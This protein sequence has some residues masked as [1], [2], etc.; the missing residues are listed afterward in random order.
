[1]RFLPQRAGEDDILLS[2]ASDK[3]VRAWRRTG[4]TFTLAATVSGVHQGSVNVLATCREH[5]GVF[6]SGAA[7]GSVAIFKIEVGE[8]VEMK[9]L[10]TITTT[11]KFYALS[12][13][14]S[15]LPTSP[16]ALILAMGGSMNNISIYAAP[17][18]T[19]PFVHCAIL[20]GH[21]NWIRSLSFTIE[22]QTSA[23]PSLLLA[24]AS[25]DR[26]IRLWRIH[27][28]T[29]LPAAAAP[30]P[31]AALN[32][33]LSNKAHML[34]LPDRAGSTQTWSVTFEALLMGHEDWI[35]TCHWSPT[36]QLLSCSADNAITIW[37]RE[38]DSGTWNPVSRFGEL[39]S[40]KGSSTATGSA[41]G[42][43]NALWSPQADAVAALTKTGSWR[44]YR[45]DSTTD[46]WNPSIGITGHT[47]SVT[48]ISWSSDGGYLLSTSLDQTTRLYARWIHDSRTS[49]HEFSRPQIHGYDINCIASTSATTFVSGA[50]EKLLRVFEQP[51]AIA[52]IL[53]SLAGITPPAT[54]A[55]PNAANLPV[56]GLSNKSIDPATG[57]TAENDEDESA[58][59]PIATAESVLAA[60]TTPPDDSSLARHTLWPETE[61]L[62][63]HGY[64]ISALAALPTATSLIAT[65]AKASTLEH[66]VIRLFDAANNWEELKPP[67]QAHSLT[68]TSLAFS[69]CGQKLLSVGRD[70]AWALF[71]VEA[72]VWGLVKKTEK[73]HT[74]ILYDCAWLP[75]GSGFVT[76]SRDK[77]VKRWTVAGELEQTVKTAKAVTAVDVSEHGQV[78][79]GMEDGGLQVWEFAEDRLAGVREWE[80]GM[81]PDGGVSRVCWR[82]G[83]REVAVAAE[84][85]SV[86]VFEI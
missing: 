15:G 4:D 47:K 5:P 13:A 11:P 9:H 39:S 35:Y 60:T 85:G 34:N 53:T 42:I 84:D 68:V 25:Q 14:L 45:H 33:R 41:G 31:I 62:Y 46:R 52:S 44:L 77:S 27:P 37:E 69:P 65:A 79:V 38:P 26:Y 28:G 3:T 80:A 24:S 21:E 51:K 29:D 19:E 20:S 66:A 8:T 10:Q 75:D 43:F 58:P 57:P 59:P 6:A 36:N 2:G 86:R 70:R 18:S 61:K 17:I 81:A 83:G 40:L 30:S 78:C 55:L 71:A 72:G 63:G 23:T 64:E 54:S 12:L 32:D 50:E 49:W 16:D 76:V 67:L 22:D 82:K 48:G 73:A 74:R 1:M 7:D 56:L